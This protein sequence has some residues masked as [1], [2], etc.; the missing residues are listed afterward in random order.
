MPARNKYLKDYVKALAHSSYRAL[1]LTDSLA[2]LGAILLGAYKGW[3]EAPGADVA[4]GTHGDPS[5]GHLTW[6]AL[7]TL[8]SGLVVVRL[9]TTPYKLYVEERRRREEL[10]L[11][12][13]PSLEIGSPI[14][15]PITEMKPGTA[16]LP[17]RPIHAAVLRIPVRNKSAAVARRCVAHV[18]EIGV[19]TVAGRT[20]I[21]ENETLDLIWMNQPRGT[22]ERDIFPGATEWL[23]VVSGRE[24]E[25]ELTLEATRHPFDSKQ[26]GYSGKYEY[27]IE[28]KSET[29]VPVRFRLTYDWDFRI[30][31]FRVSPDAITVLAS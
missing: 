14:V 27:V 24:D 31:A 21:V 1:E 28:V 13:I 26:L 15:A 22:T 18:I 11:S 25:I 7:A 8:L 19:R 3:W 5:G 16:H 29:S 10:S 23:A 30:D 2:I 17:P 6:Q 12:L 9:L 20:K 4:P